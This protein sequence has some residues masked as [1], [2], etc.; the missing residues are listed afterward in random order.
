[1]QQSYQEDN[2]DALER[3]FRGSINWMNLL[4]I[5]LNVIVYFVTIKIKSSENTAYMICYGASYAPAIRDGEWYR[6]LTS[7]FL[8]YDLEHLLN[9]MLLL[10]F[11]G[12]WVEGLVGK[13]KYIVL[14]LGG[15]LAGNVL[16]FLWDIRTGQYYYSVGASGA[17]YAIIGALLV[18]LLK[19]KGRMKDVTA[20]RVGVVLLLTIHHGLQSAG[21]DN[22]AH[23]GG[24]LGGMLFALIL[25]KKDVYD[26][27]IEST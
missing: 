10:L 12:D 18:L 3:I 27:L 21:I 19:N 8:H 14:Y 22:A 1:M 16:S 15:G 6:L 2:L 26:R 4:M 20:S 23:I 17:V 24:A 25:Y 7:M 13:W 11:I 5:G 9:N